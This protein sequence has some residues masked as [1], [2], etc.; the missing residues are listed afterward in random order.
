MDSESVREV[1][2]VVVRERTNP[3]E[4]KKKGGQKQGRTWSKQEVGRVRAHPSTEPNPGSGTLLLDEEV[5][6]MAG[7]APEREA[8]FARVWL[9]R[10]QMG[11]A[12]IEAHSVPDRPPSPPLLSS[13]RI[14]ELL[15]KKK[16][17]GFQ[18]S[19][20]RLGVTFSSDFLLPYP[21]NHHL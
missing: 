20:R 14:S 2:M 15:M 13:P 7:H 19:S 18:K 4:R 1:G 11:W 16:I 9:G 5:G 8:H 21:L 6:V 12:E 17:R 10:A 3:G